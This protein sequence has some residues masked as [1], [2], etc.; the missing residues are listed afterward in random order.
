ML[1]SVVAVSETWLH[2]SNPD[3]FNIPGYHFISNSR[4]HK[5]GGGVGLYIQSDMNLS[6]G[7]IFN[8]LTI[9][10]TNQSLWKSCDLMVK[11]LLLAASIDL[12][13]PLLMTLTGLLK[14]SCQPS[15][16][17]ISYYILWV[18]LVS[19][20]STLILINLQMSSLTL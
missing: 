7:L 14:I 18:I 10:C 8:L 19:T 4:E 6:L 17:R 1:F 3:L 2:K 5:L 13:M 11:I 16:L 9:H 12:P 15:V 20:S